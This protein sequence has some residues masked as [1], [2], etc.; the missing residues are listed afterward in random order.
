MPSSWVLDVAVDRSGT[1]YAATLRDGV[2][3]IDRKLRR[4]RLRGLPD[5]WVLDVHEDPAGLW[6]GTQAGAALVEE[7]ENIARIARLPHPNTH[8]FLRTRGQLY[9]ATE[10]GLLISQAPIPHH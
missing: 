9:V 8:A 6:V 3:A 1:A 10:G 2:V 7:D 5:S 4:R